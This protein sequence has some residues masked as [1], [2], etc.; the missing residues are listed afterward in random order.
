MN[1]TSMSDE[2]SKR[3]GS[4]SDGDDSD[5]L[6][7]SDEDKDLAAKK[8]K[9]VMNPSKP[10]KSILKPSD[11]MAGKEVKEIKKMGQKDV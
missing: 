11:H 8:N 9:N 6:A 10:S 1:M 4:N 3:N 2:S 5:E 7:N